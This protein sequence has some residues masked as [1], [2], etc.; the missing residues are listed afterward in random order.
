MK[1][2]NKNEHG[3]PSFKDVTEQLLYYTPSIMQSVFDKMGAMGFHWL[4]HEGVK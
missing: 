2:K 1:L 4:D 3:A